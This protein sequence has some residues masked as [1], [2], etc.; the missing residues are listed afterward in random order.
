M[1]VLPVIRVLLIFASLCYIT[2]GE[3][4]L[5][6]GE[7]EFYAMGEQ[8][9]FYTKG[10]CDTSIDCPSKS[11]CDE[12]TNTCVK[13][14][15]CENGSG[16]LGG[17][18]YGDCVPCSTNE[19]CGWDKK[20]F[21]CWPDHT[22]RKDPPY[23][24]YTTSFDDPD[25]IKNNFTDGEHGCLTVGLNLNDS[26][27][28]YLTVSIYNVREC[29]I[30]NNIDPRW[31]GK[32]TLHGPR[33]PYGIEPYDQ[34]NSKKTGCNTKDPRLHTSLI[35]SKRRD[36]PMTDTIPSKKRTD[37]FVVALMKHKEGKPNR[38]FDDEPMVVYYDKRDK[39]IN[40]KKSSHRYGTKIVYEGTRDMATVCWEERAISPQNIPVYIEADIL[41]HP[42]GKLPSVYDFVTNKGEDDKIT[43]KDFEYAQH[44]YFDL[45]SSYGF[46]GLKK[47]DPFA[48]E[49]DTGAF[50][51]ID[52]NNIQPTLTTIP[53]SEYSQT[54]VD[55]WTDTTWN[56]VVAS[57][58]SPNLSYT[59]HVW[60]LIVSS[61]WMIGIIV[62]LVIS[63]LYYNKREH[64]H[65][66]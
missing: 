24:A 52:S 3:S 60:I 7:A 54:W 2:S 58:E 34:D 21:F 37:K 61:I 28:K 14:E 25:K 1:T 36:T 19:Q 55:C 9:D 32:L 39:D 51:M 50:Q 40:N 31:Y 18:K 41:V 43:D 48:F 5:L 63:R 49:Y 16:R 12:D 42:S 15:E 59:V 33:A 10:M 46:N 45:L 13:V 62:Y 6:T 4:D 27:A 22:C 23:F 65:H 47:D 64:Y 38:A 44:R 26:M 66:R 56:G 17:N 20:N 11:Y 8:E 29:A 53:V 57:C 30:S 35:Y